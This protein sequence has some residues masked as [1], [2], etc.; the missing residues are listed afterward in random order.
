MTNF[1][2][3][4]IYQKYK[5]KQTK[6]PGLHQF[7]TIWSSFEAP[8]QVLLLTKENKQ[9]FFSPSFAGA[10]GKSESSKKHLRCISIMYTGGLNH[11][12]DGS[13]NEKVCL[14][15]WEAGHKNILQ[16]GEIRAEVPK[17]TA[18]LLSNL[19][20][21]LFGCL[22]RQTGKSSKG[23]VLASP[24][25]KILPNKWTSNRS[26]WD[27]YSR[28]NNTPIPLTQLCFGILW[29]TCYENSSDCKIKQPTKWS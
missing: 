18:G 6:F 13:L 10:Y 11:V 16:I 29:L 3:C 2:K 4:S 12:S 27:T 26:S 22:S 1:Q 5:W 7:L 24:S 15:F 23:V 20:V 14:S 28:P 25:P 21:F 8:S 17:R 9:I 19:R